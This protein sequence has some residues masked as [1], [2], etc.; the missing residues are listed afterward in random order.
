VSLAWQPTADGVTYKIYGRVSGSIGLLATVGPFDPDNPPAYVDAGTPAP[1][2]AP[3]GSNTTGGAA[4]SRVNLGT[5]QC[6]P[7]LIVA[8]DY[9]STFGFEARDF[10]GRALRLLDNGQHY[11]LENEF[12]TGTLAQA[13]GYP[14][15]YLANG[16]AANF[17]DLTAGT[18]V[19]VARG[20]Q[21]LQD[22]LASTGF[23]GQ[24]MIHCQ[25]QTAPNLLNARRVGKLLLDVFDNII[26]PGS[27]Y[28]GA[29]TA[30]T[31]S[32][33]GTAAMFA[34]DLVSTLVEGEGK[35]GL[36]SEDG[37]V[38]PDS[39]AEAVDRGEAGFPNNV[40]FRAIKYGCAFFDGLIQA[41]VRVNLAT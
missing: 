9:C 22:Y 5:V 37:N 13:K 33:T 40:R 1:G 4:A 30:V 17:V 14:N 34:T 20:Q 38:Y 35:V 29:A 16:S 7:F 3:P 23:G 41:G 11:A 19:S 24:G 10:K 6:Q 28:T 8:E 36:V 2:A 18:P 39:F 12:W 25:P 31:G 26:V 15:N 21:L 27:G 32:A